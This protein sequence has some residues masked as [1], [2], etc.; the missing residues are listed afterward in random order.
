MFNIIARYM[1]FTVRSNNRLNMT[2]KYKFFLLTIICSTFSVHALCQKFY[3]INSLFGISMRETNSIC[4]DDNGFVWASSKSGIL[5]ISNEDCRTYH[6][7]YETADAI[8]VEL[9][10]KNSGLYAYTNNGQIFSYNPVSDQFNLLLNLS[11][12]LGDRYL[13]VH[14]LL[15]DNSGAW[16]IATTAGLYKY[17]SEK[18]VSVDKALSV[19]YAISW[20]DSADRQLLIVG[21]KGIW[22]LETESLKTKCVYENSSSVP[23]FVSKLFFDK[24]QNKLWI[25]TMSSGL[26]CY[27]FESGTISGVLKSS[28]PR[29]PI[30]AIEANTD[31]TLL[32]GIDGQGIWEINKKGDRIRNVY[33][34]NADDPSSLKGNGVYDLF[35]DQNKRIWICTYSGGVSFFDQ[36][37]P[38][39]TQIIHHINDEN[40]LVNN[41]VNSII[42]D[43]WG[44]LWF[45]TNNGVSCWN[46]VSNE[47]KS[48]YYNKQKQAQVF[49]ALCEDDE[50]RIWAGT[51]SSGVYI[52]DGKTGNE[53]GHYSQKEK[54]SPVVSDYI[55]NIYKDHEGDIWLG[56]VN[57]MFMCYNSKENKFRAYPSE[58]V[59]SIAELS[60][61]QILL[62]CSY[63]LVLLNKQTGET[64]KLLIGLL[65][66]DLLV[67]DGDIWIG[68]GGNGLIRYNFKSG[69]KEQF[70]TQSGLPS[71]FINGIVYNDG[72]LWIGTENGLCRFDPE[73]ENVLT[74]SSIFP[75]SHASFNSGCRFKL[76]NGQLAWGTNNGA[77]MFV[78]KSLREIPAM[79]K[80]YFEDLMVSGRSIRDIPSFKLNKPV[81]S[82]KTI[83]LRYYQNT[84]SLGL[85][86]IGITSG[87]KF[88]WKME[89]LDLDWSAP[90]DNRIV[91]YANI[92][93]GKFILKI[94]LYDSS[95]SRAITERSI[96]IRIIPPFWRTA[97]FWILLFAVV[98]GII[99]LY[100]LY[101]IKSL[102]QQHTEEK[103]RFF[104]NT[105][106]DIRTS[107]TLI[108][109][110]VEELRKESSLSENGRYYLHL[111][112]EQARRLSSFVN[113]LIDFQK[114][115]VGKEQLS[116]SM[117][118]IVGLIA[119]RKIMF[120]SFAK[121]RKIELVFT[122]DLQNYMTAIDDSKIEK[123][124]DNLISNAVKYSYPGTQVHLDLKCDDHKWIFRVE[125]H[126]IGISRKAQRKLFREFYRGENAINSKVVGSGIGL[127]LVKNYVVMH[128]GKISCNSQENIGSTFQVIVPFK[129]IAEK[130]ETVNSLP[131]TGGSDTYLLPDI[132][133]R[134]ERLGNNPSRE[135]RVLIVEDNDDLRNFIHSAF[136]EEFIV[137]T[138]EDGTV[139]WKII[140]KQ[141]PDLVVSD[142][143]MP[144]MDGFE[145][146][147]LM[148][149]TYET[150]HIPIILLTAL[151][152]KAEQLHGLGLGADDYLTKPF[153]MGLLM[154]RIKTII[155]NRETIR[156][157][158]LKL[159]KGTISEPILANE[160]NDRFIKKMTEVVQDN[161]A[162]SEFDKDEFAS[163]MNV[164]PS[165]LYKKS[166]ALTN[167]SPT[168]FIKTIRL[169]HAMEL[170]QEHKCMV[171]EVSESCGYTSLGYFSTVFKKHFGKSPTEI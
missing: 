87:S 97:W 6:L 42:E 106:H 92:P 43:R 37:S 5:R 89:G 79:G 129:E 86:P 24:S 48:F 55:L 88:S 158:A 120:E 51:Y 136:K 119:K 62:G 8:T 143:M 10:Y 40:S 133:S 110:P 18:L 52:L 47:W 27:K 1:I 112:T 145:L 152:E 118:D 149:S 63:G 131:D 146:C 102:K 78:P 114:V 155:R 77:V 4:Q 124:V 142:I 66:H 50:G 113:Q 3:S 128:G 70:T 81:D 161:M 46:P 23:F 61:N 90:T 31:S 84:I 30:L 93:S 163:A 41:D 165:L 160:L 28:F 12:S 170:L 171:T 73:D 36:S 82:L 11:K 154:Q 14:D 33:K 59:N 49:L 54:K 167:Q 135:M 100:L 34:E 151:S 65:I 39:V 150:S 71:N 69:K 38:V 58:P 126:G 9:I 83:N 132:T 98:S 67:L 19:L 137:F 166:K 122:T 104:T 144:N 2:I 76:K 159:K 53:L 123:I 115:D 153:D 107:L 13:S 64:K 168:E 125:D 105:S 96:I 45:A 140:Q 17:Q 22:I 116:L 57:G 35:C 141:I 139:A 60:G 29:Q 74:Y 111:A 16:W 99:F 164:S 103:I 72:Y 138:A 162:N 56:G 75:L 117:M 94:K 26:Y 130:K 25:G 7:P 91:T 169:N 121:S 85:L 44:K 68:T 32:I 148:K 21:T 109:A 80:I 147:K 101:Y 127:L 108:K 15:I 95:L 20:F 157:K 134:S 156:E